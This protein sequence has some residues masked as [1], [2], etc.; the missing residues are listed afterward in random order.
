M[1]YY[2]TAKK[3]ERANT[4]TGRC[5]FLGAE[6]PNG[7]NEPRGRSR[8]LYQYAIEKAHKAGIQCAKYVPP[9]LVRPSFQ[10]TKTRTL[11]SLLDLLQ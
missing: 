1:R 8:L 11:S 4:V 3:G 5:S 9:P 6:S 7:G 10:K 2:E